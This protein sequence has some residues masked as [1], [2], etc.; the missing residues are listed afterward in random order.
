MAIDPLYKSIGAVIKARRRTL[1]MKQEDLA[2]ML[3]ISR[4]SL[5]NI[6]TGRQSI[7]VHQL[8]RF[9]NA[10]D[11]TPFDLLPPP[12]T[13]HFRPDLA[14]FP[15]PH[16]LKVQQKEQIT[17]LLEQVDIDHKPATEV[18]RAKNIKR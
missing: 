10:L 9:A 6:E 1:G 16:D 13:E 4:G 3:N 17:R 8:F 14:G 11:V 2:R 18:S 7:L 15:L 5:A 12:S